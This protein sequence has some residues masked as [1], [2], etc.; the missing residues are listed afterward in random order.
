MHISR[1]VSAHG[2]SMDVDADPEPWTW[3]VP[4]GMPD[5][6]MTS[7]CRERERRGLP[8]VTQA[9]VRRLIADAWRR[10]A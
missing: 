7:V 4:C 5:V 9:E 1:G 2:F 6:E 10:E 8:P 3:A